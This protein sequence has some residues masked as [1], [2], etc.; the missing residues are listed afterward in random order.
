[1]HN[2]VAYGS[3][4][5]Y[6]AGMP[7]FLTF[8]FFFAPAEA[9]FVPRVHRYDA[10]FVQ[11]HNGETDE[12]ARRCHLDITLY[13]PVPG[14]E[15]WVML[16]LWSDFKSRISFKPL[17]PT[18]LLPLREGATWTDSQGRSYLYQGGILSTFDGLIRYE[19]D[20]HFF[21]P[22]K[23]EGKSPGAPGRSDTHLYCEF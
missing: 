1:M 10:T 16:V 3:F 2:S 21:F 9:S 8:L 20:G 7:L 23:A 11:G 14:G 19:I 5:A 13:Y 4:L 6:K 15:P 22:V 12:S 17:I 18:S